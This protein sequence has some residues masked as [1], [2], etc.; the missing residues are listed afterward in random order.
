MPWLSI[1]ENFKSYITFF[2][3]DE[4]KL[5][6]VSLHIQGDI[7]IY[8]FQKTFFSNRLLQGTDL[9][10]AFLGHISSW[11]TPSLSPWSFYP[12]LECVP[13]DIIHEIHLT[14]LSSLDCPNKSPNS[15][16]CPCPPQTPSSPNHFRCP[17]PFVWIM[18]SPPLPPWSR[19]FMEIV[20]VCVWRIKRP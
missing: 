14:F 12:V 3:A 9:R 4:A 6:G 16:T 13:V 7:Y 8:L 19:Y 15:P 10:S 18:V 17:V 5:C 11:Q 1:P 2:L 20:Y